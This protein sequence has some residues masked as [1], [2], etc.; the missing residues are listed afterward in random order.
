LLPA[1][2]VVPQ[3]VPPHS[4]LK[5]KIGAP[6]N[7]YGIKPGRHWDGVDRSNGFER[8]LFKQQN[9]AVALQ[10]EARAWGECPL[11]VLGLSSCSWQR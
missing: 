5:R 11:P 7:R 2:F 6:P 4:W 3:Q 8:E 1:G 9:A 10:A